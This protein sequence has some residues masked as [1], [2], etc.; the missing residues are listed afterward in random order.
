MMTRDCHDI[1][2]SRT[3]V[4]F[5]IFAYAFMTSSASQK[6]TADSRTPSLTPAEARAL[7]GRMARLPVGTLT[8]VVAVK[9]YKFAYGNHRWLVTP[10]AGTGETWTENIVPL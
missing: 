7:V 1:L 5:I 8:F 10:T 4:P 2:R 9:D 6:P 3:I